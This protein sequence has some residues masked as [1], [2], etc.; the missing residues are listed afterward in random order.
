ML[1]VFQGINCWHPD[2]SPSEAQ[3]M[4]FFFLSVCS[5]LHVSW[6]CL[7]KKT[8]LSSMFS[9][10][11]KL[12]ET[13]AWQDEVTLCH[14]VLR[15]WISWPAALGSPVAFPHFAFIS[16]QDFSPLSESN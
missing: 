15:T 4:F 8:Q 1:K 3:L 12:W 2:R 6:F 11:S 9:I 13:E 16:R 5:S 7:K 14:T 10:S